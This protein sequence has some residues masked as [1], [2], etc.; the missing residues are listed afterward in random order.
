M[1]PVI[2]STVLPLSRERLQSLAVHDRQTN[3]GLDADDCIALYQRMFG[4]DPAGTLEEKKTTGLSDEE[5]AQ[6]CLVVGGHELTRQLDP[7][8]NLLG[9]HESSF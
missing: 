7:S 8:S 2:D 1:A 5:G 9:I 4:S 3:S 6:S